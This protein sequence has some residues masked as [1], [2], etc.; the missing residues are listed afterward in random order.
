MSA[1]KAKSPNQTFTSEH[2]YDGAADAP[3]LDLDYFVPAVVA[4]GSEVIHHGKNSQP[5][6][7]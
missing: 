7:R 3:A 1:T 6:F 4:D 5:A 2:L